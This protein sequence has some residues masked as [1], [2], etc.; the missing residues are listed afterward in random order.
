MKK[1]QSFPIER[2]ALGGFTLIETLIAI[3]IL[4]LSIVGPFQVVQ[5]VLS[6]AYNARDQLVAAGLAQ[7]AMEYTRM[8]RD[9]NYLY[10]AQVGANTVTWLNGM[11]GNN[12]PNCYYS[13]APAN[14]NHPCRIEPR[15][16]D[17][18]SSRFY[19]NG[20]LVLCTDSTGLSCPHP[21]YVDSF[22]VYNQQDIGTVSKYTRVMT[23]TKINDHET[24]V[25]VTVTWENHGAKSVTVSENLQDWL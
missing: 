19:A 17:V 8:V 1:L 4:T 21:L 14:G 18:T 2:Q 16:M 3:L 7:E 25:T 6:S 13:P 12:G 23:L 20:S 9:S 10:N 24:M 5:G 15:A 22:G 11:D